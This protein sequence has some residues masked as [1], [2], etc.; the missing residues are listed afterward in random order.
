MKRSIYILI[1]IVSCTLPNQPHLNIQEKKLFT[2]LEHKFKCK[3]DRQYSSNYLRHNENGEYILIFRTR[4]T[5]E[6]YPFIADSAIFLAREI[7]N[8]IIKSDLKIKS[9]EYHLMYDMG[10]DTYLNKYL[11]Y[12]TDSL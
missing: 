12:H 8:T 11:T 9:I 1:L 10:N 2:K 7:K 3:I 6:L 4:D 5:S